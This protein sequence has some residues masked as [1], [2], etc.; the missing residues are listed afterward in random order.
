MIR[1]E[2]TRFGGLGSPIEER[3]NCYMACLASIFELPL[4]EGGV[5]DVA[6]D[7]SGWDD[8]DRFMN[9]HGIFLVTLTIPMEENLRTWP[10]Y[11]LAHVDSYFYPPEE[12]EP[13][14]ICVAFNGE[15]V[16]NPNPKDP[17][18]YSEIKP[19]LFTIFYPLDPARLVRG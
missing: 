13:N 8:I 5:P 4:G 1:V 17:R 19:K 7:D 11:C 18:P 16:W 10:V 9:E 2:Q 12:W 6:S 3:G 15:I 14:H